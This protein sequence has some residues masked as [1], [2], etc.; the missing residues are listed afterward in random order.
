MRIQWLFEGKGGDSREVED[1]DQAA[2]VLADAVRTAYDQ[3]DTDALALVLVNVLAPLRAELVTDG[4]FAVER[5]HEWSTVKGGLLVRL[6]PGE[7]P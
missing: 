2:R 1:V 6:Y 4:R 3:L 7:R 5:G